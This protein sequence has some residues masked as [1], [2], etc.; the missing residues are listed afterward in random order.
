M[1]DVCEAHGLIVEELR[2]MTQTV[3]ETNVS[4]KDMTGTMA[5]FVKLVD[6]NGKEPLTTRLATLEIEAQGR[7]E[8]STI[9][10]RAGSSGVVSLLLVLL[11]ALG[12]WLGTASLKSLRHDLQTVIQ[13][14]ETNGRVSQ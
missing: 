5:R 8:R 12:G 9:W 4:V 1:T 11:L 3:S 13:Q 7:R 2:K 14:T 6:G 10:A